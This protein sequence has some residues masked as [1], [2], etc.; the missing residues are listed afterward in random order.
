MYD[1]AHE[2]SLGGGTLWEIHPIGQIDVRKDGAWHV[3]AH[4]HDRTLGLL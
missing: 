1:S 3:S 2:G 4:S